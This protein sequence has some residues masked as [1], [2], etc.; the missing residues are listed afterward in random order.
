MP[1]S[2]IYYHSNKISLKENCN[3]MKFVFTTRQHLAEVC[4]RFKRKQA[5]DALC[6][7]TSSVIGMCGA[8][9]GCCASAIS[10]R[11][12]AGA[13]RLLRVFARR[14]RISPTA[15]RRAERQRSGRRIVVSCV[16]TAQLLHH[17]VALRAARCVRGRCRQRRPIRRFRER[18]PRGA[19]R[20]P[21]AFK[22]GSRSDPGTRGPDRARTSAW[23]RCAKPTSTW[24]SLRFAHRR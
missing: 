5:A 6:A 9:S 11:T 18:V 8:S 15:P 16:G 13:E 19:G 22:R 20:V 24:S 10:R 12:L 1:A 23:P 14:R 21:P 3:T 4:A 17:A 7:K 2:P